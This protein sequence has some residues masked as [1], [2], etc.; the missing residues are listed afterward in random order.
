MERV[1]FPW[2]P[3]F[4]GTFL[5][6]SRPGSLG[7]HSVFLFG[8]QMKL[9]SNIPG[10]SRCSEFPPAALHT[11]HIPASLGFVSVA[12]SAASRRQSSPGPCRQWSR[13][14][15]RKKSRST[16]RLGYFRLSVRT[17]P[18]PKRRSSNVVANHLMKQ[19]C[20]RCVSLWIMTIRRH[21]FDLRVGIRTPAGVP[22]VRREEQTF[23]ICVFIHACPVSKAKHGLRVRQRS[24]PVAD[25]AS[26]RPGCVL[27]GVCAAGAPPPFAQLRGTFVSI[28]SHLLSG[29]MKR[30]SITRG[31][32]PGLSRLGA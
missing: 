12:P 22:S 1:D 15:P 21:R 26:A 23:A 11:H 7:V 31:P 16:V 20:N 2:P 13:V 4:Y 27:C 19:S 5:N 28:L 9:H 24:Y 18:L 25:D 6:N 29:F 8:I 14:V 30:S 32:D 10:C 3:T 17:S